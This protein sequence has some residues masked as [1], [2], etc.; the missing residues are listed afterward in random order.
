MLSF[1]KRTYLW[2]LFLPLLIQFLGIASNQLVLIANH[3]TFP[4]LVSLAHAKW[5]TGD[6]IHVAMTDQT[7]LNF[8]ADIFDFHEIIESIGDLLFQLGEWLQNFSSVIWFVL[9]VR[10]MASQ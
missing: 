4:V 3:D 9:A 5:L 2:V 7:H 6:P 8:L 10:K 1:I